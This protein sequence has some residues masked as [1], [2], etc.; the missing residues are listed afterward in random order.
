MKIKA[1]FFDLDG[2]LLHMDQDT[3]ISAYLGGL[4]KILAPR[5]YD[6]T[7]IGSALWQSTAAMMKNDGSSSNEEVFWNS[8]AR[9]LGE[10]VRSEEDLIQSFY[11]GDFQEISKVC[12]YQPRAKAI[13]DMLRSK[14]MP[15]ILATSPLFP[16]IATHSR[17][18]WAGLDPSCFDYITTFENSNYC[19]PNPKYY[20]DLLEKTGYKAWECLMIGN[21]V[22]DDMIAASVGMNVYLVTNDLINRKNID[23]TIF[24]HGDF[25]ELCEYLEKLYEE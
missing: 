5:G 25:D 19:K 1:I 2:T 12:G 13:I 9:I 11:E 15:L 8:F 6:P 3:F 16:T 17:I 4:V 23:I 10:S 24:E 7:L 14:G 22:G 18:K 20:V 21:D